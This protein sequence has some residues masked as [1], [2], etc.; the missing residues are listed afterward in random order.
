MATATVVAT[1]KSRE[2]GRGQVIGAFRRER[3]AGRPLVLFCVDR[4]RM[5]VAA[6]RE[7][8]RNDVF[9]ILS[10][11]EPSPRFAVIF[12]DPIE[13]EGIIFV[14]QSRCEGVKFFSS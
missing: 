11:Q 8:I 2:V 9:N 3:R 1:A 4:T 14:G 7:K 6:E 12:G 5:R 13:K 10:C